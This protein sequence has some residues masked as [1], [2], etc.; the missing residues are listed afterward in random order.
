MN[1]QQQKKEYV[2]ICHVGMGWMHKFIEIM[3]RKVQ[4]ITHANIDEKEPVRRLLERFWT[5]TMSRDN[6][7]NR[8]SHREEGGE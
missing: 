1:Q 8:S 2:Y 5:E 4:R 3:E 7:S 6:R